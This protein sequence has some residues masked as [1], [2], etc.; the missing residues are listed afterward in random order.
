ME[1][2]K[3]KNI[4]T[5]KLY[6][7]KDKESNSNLKDGRDYSAA[8]YVESFHLDN[9][10]PTKSGKDV[11]VVYIHPFDINIE[12]EWRELNEIDLFEVYEFDYHI[13]KQNLFELKKVIGKGL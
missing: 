6:F 9:G 7:F 8:G 13:L 3:M 11:C 1:N 2:E 4:D 5:S 10:Q 12:C